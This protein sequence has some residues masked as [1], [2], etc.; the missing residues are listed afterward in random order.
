MPM[1]ARDELDR[2]ATSRAALIVLVRSLSLTDLNTPIDDG[3]W[4]VKVALAHLAFWT[5][6]SAHPFAS[7]S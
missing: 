4:T 3:D 5:T 2:N 1:P 6:A 7:T